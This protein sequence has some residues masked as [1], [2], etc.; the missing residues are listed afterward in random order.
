M[1]RS[2]SLSGLLSWASLLTGSVA[3]GIADQHADIDLINYYE[4]RPDRERFCTL[5]PELGA[6]SEC[7][8]HETDA[9]FSD[10]YRLDD[11]LVQM[12]ASSLD[13]M[14]RASRR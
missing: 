1:I 14:E 9:G 7:R 12:G 6:E 5:M 2:A 3:Q 4:T 10:D 13:R 11:V 8:G